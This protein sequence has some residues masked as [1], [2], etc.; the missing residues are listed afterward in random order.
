MHAPALFE[1]PQE[2]G[3][4]NW[5]RRY[6]KK[7]RSKSGRGPAECHPGRPMHA[8]GLC[9]TCYTTSQRERVYKGRPC[10][11][12]DCDRVPQQ[13]GMCNAHYSRVRAGLDLGTPIRVV[14]K[15]MSRGSLNR[16]GY[17]YIKVSGKRIFEHRLVMEQLLDRPLLSSETVHH[18]NG[19]RADNRPE[20]LELWATVQ[21]RGQRVSDLIAFVVANYPRD[22]LAKLLESW[23]T[24]PPERVRRGIRG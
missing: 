5:I 9:T 13:K 2:A 1:L 21:P 16:D 10:S 3:T 7:G 11:V 15:G 4:D 22:V 6:Y 23:E 12:E 19:D 20:N 24:A 18:I 14:A 17:R 8:H